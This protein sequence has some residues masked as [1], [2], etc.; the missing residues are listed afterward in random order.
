MLRKALILFIAFLLSGCSPRLIPLPV[1]PSPVP[2]P[3]TDTPVPLNAPQVT[4][5]GLTAIHMIDANNGWG[6]SETT[7]L[8]TLDG[9]QTWYDLGPKDA[10]QL[11]YAA[12]S[13]FL[14]SQHGWV[15][16][17]DPSDMLK[18]TLF[19]TVDGGTSWDRIAVPFGGGGLDFLDA[20]SGWMMASLGAG[21]GS[22]GVAIYRTL[23]G[24]S[25]WT[26]AYTNDPNQPGAG[27]SL[28]LGGL[29]NGLSAANMSTAWVGGVTYTPGVV[30]VYRST[31]AGVTWQQVNVRA[32][33]GYDQADLSAL[34]PIFVSSNMAYLPV[35]VSS[36]N[37]VMLAIYVS[38]DGGNTWAVTPT[39]IP[40][41]GPPDFVSAKDGFSW[42]GASFYVT[43][44]GAQTWTAITPDVHFG[45]DF[46]GMDFVSPTTGWV[47]T[48]DASGAHGLF[49][50]T[51]GGATWNVLGH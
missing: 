6:V 11:G 49:K 37:G 46:A 44:D 45:G 12:T 23:D 34:A 39:M 50:T 16:V 51:D 33:D 30:Y 10:G 21:A 2:P 28:P 19:R 8:R 48:S 17:A 29:K 41:G 1:T 3:A 14:D 20:K 43:H 36:Q 40:Q 5:P 9:G 27:D 31:D 47:I 24:G 13:A 25:T 15:L 42:N 22:M 26:Q 18:G 4:A 7:V 35:T 32:P 38:K